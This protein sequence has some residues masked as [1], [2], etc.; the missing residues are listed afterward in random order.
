MVSPSTAT[1]LA[2][3]AAGGLTALTLLTVGKR[4]TAM[5]KAPATEV[6]AIVAAYGA[7]AVGVMLASPEHRPSTIQSAAAMVRG[8]SRGAI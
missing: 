7:V 6:L 1:T 4:W 5:G 8:A 3:L 2:V